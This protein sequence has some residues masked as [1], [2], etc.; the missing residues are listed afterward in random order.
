VKNGILKQLVKQH[1]D[2]AGG[3]IR[4]AYDQAANRIGALIDE[5]KISTK[6]FSFRQMFEELVDVPLSADVTQVAEALN[7]SAFPT[8]ASTI[9]HKDIIKEYEAQVAAYETLVSESKARLTTREKIGGFEAMDNEPQMRPEAMAY[10]ETAFGEKFWE[11][12]MADFGRMISVTRETIYEDHTN[13]VMNRARNIGRAAGQHKARMIIQTLECLP[14]TA[15]NE[16]TFQGAIYKGTALNQAAMYSDDHSTIDGVVNDNLAAN[17]ALATYQNIDNAMRLFAD[18]VD[19]GG[20][21]INI[22]PSIL[23][24]PRALA[25]TA[26]N[27][28]NTTT[29]MF[30]GGDATSSAEPSMNPT[31]NPIRALGNFQVIDTTYLGDNTTWYLGEPRDQMKWLTVYPPATASQG[32]N[33]ELAFTNQIVARFRFSYHGGVGHSDYRHIVR[34]TA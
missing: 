2:Q 25:V 5:G 12:I 13:E 31:L 8:F 21:K 33:S 14:R 3:N 17:N 32:A 10:E 28:M 19:E 24:V 6:D 4:E 20:N 29:Y 22:T 26:Y 34:N 11:V 23:L 7:T 15:F 9:L 27:I 30:S 18:M 16:T 1:E